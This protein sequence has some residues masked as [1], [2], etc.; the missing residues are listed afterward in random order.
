MC[1]L[2]VKSGIG[3]G[4]FWVQPAFK[5]GPRKYAV[6]LP[7]VI[8]RGALACVGSLTVVS[9]SELHTIHL[10]LP[11]GSTWYLGPRSTS[12]LQG[13]VLVY[14]SKNQ[15]GWWLLRLQ[16]QADRPLTGTGGTG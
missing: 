4:Y 9:E 6:W 16:E 15:Q 1:C 3:Q 8:V 5:E 11:I 13:F 12:C 2:G 10:V 7:G 14:R